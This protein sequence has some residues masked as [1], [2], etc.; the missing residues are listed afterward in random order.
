[1]KQQDRI[2]DAFRRGTPI[3]EAIQAAVL[4]ALAQHKRAGH[5]IAE[6]RNGKVIWIAPE[7]IDLDAL[8]KKKRASRKRA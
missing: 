5:P 3:D 1:V 6:W 2:E 4:E 8:G 7:N